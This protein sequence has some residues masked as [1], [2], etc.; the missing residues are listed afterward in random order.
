MGGRRRTTARAS[1]STSASA[2]RILTRNV[3]FDVTGRYSR[4]RL[5][6]RFTN[7]GASNDLSDVGVLIGFQ[8]YLPE[9]SF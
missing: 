5:R 2:S 7:I 8:I 4:G 9:F 6:G 3:A 1:A